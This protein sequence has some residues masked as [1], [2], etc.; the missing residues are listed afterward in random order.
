MTVDKKGGGRKRRQEVLER[1]LTSR[2]WGATQVTYNGHPLYRFQ[3][4]AKAG[5]INGQG[6]DQ[7]GAKWY[8]V[9]TKG[10]A[11]VHKPKHGGSPKPKNT[12]GGY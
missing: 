3:G 1:P 9:D 4:D 12:G 10:K 7:F 11:V 8:V 6:L 2:G 5:Q